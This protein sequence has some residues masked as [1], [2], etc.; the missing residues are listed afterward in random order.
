[1]PLPRSLARFNRRVT[2]K[3]TSTFARRLPGFGIVNHRGRRSGRGYRTPVNMFRRLG[4]FAIPLTYGTHSEWTR[5]VLA[6]GAAEID[7]RGRSRAVVNPRIERD[8]ARAYVPRPIRPILRWLDVD[9]FL[10]LDES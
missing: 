9:A 7:T 2:N 1:V 6:A 4:G 8:E 3:V 5:N 10:L